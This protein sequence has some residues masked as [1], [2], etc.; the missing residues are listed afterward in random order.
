VL[1]DQYRVGS[2]HHQQEQHS[3]KCYTH[4]FAQRHLQVVD[5][6]PTTL[7]RAQQRPHKIH[8]PLFFHLEA[9]MW[10]LWDKHRFRGKHHQL[11]PLR[12]D[13]DIVRES[14]GENALQISSFVGGSGDASRSKQGGIGPPKRAPISLA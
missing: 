4:T 8:M 12:Y 9:R 1:V 3:H 10:L 13:P 7:E 11:C 2:A 6:L 5:A 14:I